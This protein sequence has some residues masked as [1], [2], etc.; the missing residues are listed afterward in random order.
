MTGTHRR[1]SGL[2][3]WWRVLYAGNYVLTMIRTQKAVGRENLG[4]LFAWDL[5]T[6]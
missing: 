4:V 5:C 1:A 6:I 3:A 2:I